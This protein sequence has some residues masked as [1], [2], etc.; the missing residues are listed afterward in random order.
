[1]KNQ[2]TLEIMQVLREEIIKLGIQDNPS[3]SIYQERYTRGLAP[4]PNAI[5]H[6][7]GMSWQELMQSI[8]FKYDGLAQMSTGG[9]KGG[10]TKGKK[11]GQSG[12]TGYKKVSNEELIDQIRKCFDAEKFISIEG[13][14][15]GHGSYAPS[16]STIR[17]RLGWG[18]LAELE[19]QFTKIAGRRIT[20]R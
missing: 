16:L 17:R 2:S 15:E 7:T 8:G 10:H 14:K 4:N 18:T 13:Y 1:M 19:E 20:R 9:R 3:R 5:M 12:R 11:K 6:R